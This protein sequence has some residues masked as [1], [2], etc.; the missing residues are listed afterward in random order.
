MQE[1]S[2]F[3]KTF[4]T[5]LQSLSEKFC[6]NKAVLADIDRLK[7][8]AMSFYRQLEQIDI[9]DRELF[10]Q[11]QERIKQCAIK[12]ER[13]AFD[14]LKAFDFY[15]TRCSDDEQQQKIS[16]LEEHYFASL[17]SVPNIEILNYIL[18]SAQNIIAIPTPP[19]EQEMLANIHRSFYT[20]EEQASLLPT[21][22]W[23]AL[24]SRYQK[25]KSMIISI[26]GNYNYFIQESRK[27]DL[28][29]QQEIE[30]LPQADKQEVSAFMFAKLQL[31][32][33]SKTCKINIK[34]DCL[35]RLGELGIRESELI[36][37]SRNLK[38][39]EE[40]LTHKQLIKYFNF[41]C[42]YGDEITQSAANKLPWFNSERWT[43]K[44]SIF[45]IYP[46]P[47]YPAKL[48]KFKVKA[49]KNKTY[50]FW[51][52]HRQM[53]ALRRLIMPFVQ[54]N[55]TEISHKAFYA[56]VANR[57]ITQTSLFFNVF[58]QDIKTSQSVYNE[59]EQTLEALY[60]K[61]YSLKTSSNKLLF[62]GTHHLAQE[63]LIFVD[64]IYL[65][66][67]NHH[68]ELIEHIKDKFIEWSRRTFD[69][70]AVTSEIRQCVQAKIDG[71]VTDL[72]NK[73]NH[74]EHLRKLHRKEKN[75]ISQ[76]FAKHFNKLKRSFLRRQQVE[77]VI[78]S[79]EIS[80]F[81]RK[82][83]RLNEISEEVV[84]HLQSE[85]FTSPDPEESS[86]QFFKGHS[87]TSSQLLLIKNTAGTVC[88]ADRPKFWIE[89]SHKHEVL[90]TTINERLQT[91]T[92]DRYI[93]AWLAQ[94]VEYLL[95]V[96]N[97]PLLDR[98]R[99]LLR[100][101]L[102]KTTPDYKAD[103]CH[104]IKKLGPSNKATKQW[105]LA[106]INQ[107]QEQHD[108]AM[109][110]LNELL[111]REEDVLKN[112]VAELMESMMKKEISAINLCDE[113]ERWDWELIMA[114]LSK[115]KSK[116]LEVGQVIEAVVS[117]GIALKNVTQQ[118]NRFEQAEAA[119]GSQHAVAKAAYS[120][121]DLLRER[122]MFRVQQRQ[123]P[124]T[125]ESSKDFDVVTR[126]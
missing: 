58:I 100:N 15:T 84:A 22:I 47:I 16:V 52:Y 83:I 77:P 65:N 28:D 50:L 19:G 39:Q 1:T 111:V 112:K 18:C 76:W 68:I 7:N 29:K 12:A 124:E 108:A 71:R 69:N 20:E 79:D 73:I 64:M 63:L 5:N 51:D 86:N 118:H 98:L 25:A 99:T 36:L 26:Q 101:V 61:I 2:I 11:E 74:L 109:Q 49:F 62:R 10:Q 9:T 59:M 81:E 95:A 48:Q 110:E 33:K 23:D 30:R 125:L 8:A 104:L 91:Q 96:K 57:T 38:T 56:K 103:M 44:T 43:Y 55:Q 123:E 105:L 3:E 6:A 87:V 102:S 60:S 93:L 17:Y 78:S 32:A 85:L 34:K 54:I 80:V 31:A 42:E 21:E 14:C 41:I 106:S 66:L 13:Q 88:L 126:V 107:W 70:P 117:T 89:N 82:R 122:G 90:L 4:W 67:I 115:N 75:S 116:S 92:L 46:S 72:Q 37:F 27:W 120:N 24:K 35:E 114:V 113:D 94:A 45:G 119:Y 97:E 53:N 40:E 121:A